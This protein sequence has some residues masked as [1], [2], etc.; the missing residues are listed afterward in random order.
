MAYDGSRWLEMD[1]A[2]Y[3]NPY[4]SPPRRTTATVL[5]PFNYLTVTLLLQ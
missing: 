2:D 5:S 4:I 1:G 3:D